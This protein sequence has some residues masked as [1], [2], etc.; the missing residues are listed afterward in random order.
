MGLDLS[1][2]AVVDRTERWPYHGHEAR[3]AEHQ[4]HHAQSDAVDFERQTGTSTLEKFV[5]AVDTGQSGEE[6]RKLENLSLFI[7]NKLL[8]TSSLQG[9][10]AL[11]LHTMI[12]DRRTH[13][14][15]R[16]P[17]NVCNVLL[18]EGRNY[19]A[20]KHL[21]RRLYAIAPATEMACI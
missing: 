21:R 6:I 7:T 18:H 17:V 19:S 5:H 2:V 1:Q 8:S 3:E 10:H 20:E 14:L 4:R 12:N 16:L 9:L 11:P 13:L 15:R